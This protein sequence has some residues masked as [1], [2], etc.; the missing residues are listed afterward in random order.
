MRLYE[1]LPMPFLLEAKDDPT[2]KP[3]LLLIAR[4]AF[5]AGFSFFVKLRVI[6]CSIIRE[7]IGLL[8][9]LAAF[10][11]DTFFVDKSNCG[12]SGTDRNAFDGDFDYRFYFCIRVLGV[13][14]LLAATGGRC[15]EGADIVRRC[16]FFSS[17]SAGKEPPEFSS[18][19]SDILKSTLCS[20]SSLIS[21][22]ITIRGR[23][24]MLGACWPTW[25]IIM[26]E[27]LTEGSFLSSGASLI[28][29]FYREALLSV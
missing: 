28:Y 4:R 15:L 20:D 12:R 11:G 29:Y 18:G 16:S 8:A 2:D 9:L 17:S 22:A 14:K 19:D 1:E 23:F 25:F 27:P 26:L 5:M 13:V 21:V 24:F 3:R 10:T 6:V 7:D